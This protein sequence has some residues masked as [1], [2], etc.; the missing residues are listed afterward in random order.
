MKNKEI[1][2]NDDEI[3]Y[4]KNCFG[5]EPCFCENKEYVKTWR[6]VY[7]LMMNCNPSI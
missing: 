6:F 3:L 2:L 5:Y 1:E 4:C 7:E